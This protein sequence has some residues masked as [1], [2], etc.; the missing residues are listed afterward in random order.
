M[1]ISGTLLEKTLRWLGSTPSRNHGKFHS[2]QAWAQ[3]LPCGSYPAALAWPTAGES[4]LSSAGRETHQAFTRQDTEIASH[5]PNLFSDVSHL[6]WQQHP[7]G[8][9]WRKVALPTPPRGELVRS[10]HLLLVFA[11]AI[12]LPHK[13]THQPQGLPPKKLSRTLVEEPLA[14]VSVPW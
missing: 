4:E 13:A 1:A 5:R 7:S 10:L 8:V 11:P 3:R 9:Q 6:P 2:G 14:P 12:P